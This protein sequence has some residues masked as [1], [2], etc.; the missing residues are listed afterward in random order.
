MPNSPPSPH[1]AHTPCSNIVALFPDD[2][3]KMVLVVRRDLGM[4]K[5]KIA[6][7]CGHAVLGCYKAAVRS[8]PA[9]ANRHY[10]P[11]LCRY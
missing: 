9:A 2:A 5:G 3:Y 1:G 11:R 4:N 6:A 8:Q 7:Q 10:M